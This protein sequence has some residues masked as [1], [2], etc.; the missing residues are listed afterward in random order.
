MATGTSQR[1]SLLKELEVSR[2]AIYQPRLSVILMASAELTF[3]AMSHSRI[4]F[5][6]CSRNNRHQTSH[7]LNHSRTS[8]TVL[9]SFRPLCFQFFT[10]KL[11]ARCWILALQYS[12]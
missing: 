6:S 8:L 9:I 10:E 2:T 11:R 4:S 1:E 12:R 5:P 7:S 3:K